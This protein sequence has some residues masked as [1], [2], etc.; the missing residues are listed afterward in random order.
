MELGS[1]DGT[2]PPCAS[3]TAGEQQLPSLPARPGMPQPGPQWVFI[4]FL[5]RSHVFSP[6]AGVQGPQGVNEHPLAA[7]TICCSL[8]GTHA[9]APTPG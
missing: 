6:R 4:F 5:L 3:S 9:C 8:C 7:C 2:E 1:G